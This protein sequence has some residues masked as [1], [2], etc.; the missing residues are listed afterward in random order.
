MKGKSITDFN[1][2]SRI[3]ENIKATHQADAIKN[4]PSATAICKICSK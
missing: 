4:S 1:P 3:I 2:N